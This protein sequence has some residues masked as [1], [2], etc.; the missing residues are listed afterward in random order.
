MNIKIGFNAVLGEE[1][2]KKCQER[3]ALIVKECGNNFVSVIKQLKKENYNF[4]I[5]EEDEEVN[6]IVYN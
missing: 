5:E 6:N 2:L 4:K 3:L 1:A